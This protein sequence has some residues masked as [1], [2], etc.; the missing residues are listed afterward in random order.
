MK[1]KEK[2]YTDQQ[3][4]FMQALRDPDNKGNLRT[5]MTLAGYSDKTAI[6]VI[7]QTLGEEIIDI[8]HQLL[9]SHAA[10]AA[11]SM[12]GVLYEPGLQSKNVIAA[13]KEILDRAGVSKKGDG[14]VRMNVG[15]GLLILPAKQT[16]DDE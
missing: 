12:V 14:D 4:L 9:A 2:I 6:S 15:G 13:A 7:V 10:Q 16:E 1:N 3:K 8:A 11:L 5:C